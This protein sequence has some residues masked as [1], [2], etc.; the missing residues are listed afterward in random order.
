M[1]VQCDR[2]YDDCTRDDY[3]DMDNGDIWCERCYA[4]AREWRIF[5]ISF[6]CAE[7]KAELLCECPLIKCP[8]CKEEIHRCMLIDKIGGSVC[9]VCTHERELE[10]A[11][12]RCRECR[13]EDCVLCEL[14]AHREAIDG[15]LYDSFGDRHDLRVAVT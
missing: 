5:L 6:G 13:D 8:H 1:G 15:Y 2:C 3:Q 11:A 4:M 10:Q 9:P 7:L 14:Q 12:L